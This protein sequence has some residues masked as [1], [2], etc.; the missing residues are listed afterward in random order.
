MRTGRGEAEA[1]GGS[2]SVVRARLGQGSVVQGTGWCREVARAG[3]G[4]GGSGLRQG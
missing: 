3:G 4:S 1:V 2:G